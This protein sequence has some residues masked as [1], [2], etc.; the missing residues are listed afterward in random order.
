[1]H[2]H[3]VLVLRD[4]KRI[5]KRLKRKPGADVIGDLERI[6]RK[7]RASIR[8]R[9]KRKN[10]VPSFTYFDHL[11]ITSKKDEIIDAIKKNKVIVVS[12]ETGSGKT[13]QLPKF[14]LDA[15]RGIEGKIGCTQPRRIAATTVSRRIAE[16]MGQDIGQ[17]VGY[18]IRFQEKT[19]PDAYIKVMTDGILLAETQGDPWLNE[20]DTIIVD[21]AHERS[22][23]ID[24]VLGILQTLVEKRKNLKLIITSATI[25]TEKFSKAFGN[26]KVLEVSGRTYP[27]ETRYMNDTTDKDDDEEGNYVEMAIQ[28][29]ERIQAETP[30]GDI[31]V[32]MPTEHDIRE[33]CELIQG[34]KFKNTT[35][36]PLF[37]RL[38][39]S[40]Q[41]K[42]FSRPRGRKIIVATNIAETSITI[43][44]IKYVVDTGVARI[45]QYLPRSR[46]T[47]LP[48]VPVSRSSAD[49]RKGRCGRVEN[50][51]CIRLFSEEGYHQRPLFTQPEILRSNL[52]EV[53]LRM[54]ALKL[55]DITAFPFIDRPAGKSIKDGLDLLMELGAIERKKTRSIKKQRSRP[56]SP[57]YVLTKTGRIMAMLPIDPRLSRML[58]EGKNRGCLREMVILAGALS[59]QDPRERPLDK[60]AQA[61]QAHA[62]F[63]DP[64][65]DFITLLNI[66]DRFR[67]VYKAEKGMSRMRKF[68]RKNFLSFNR[69]REWGDI[70]IQIRAVLKE[71]GFYQAKVKNPGKPG[72]EKGPVE[73]KGGKE[74]FHPRYAA[75]HQSILSGF[76]SNIAEK[77][78]KHFFRAAKGREVMIFPGSGI[79]KDPGEWVVAAEMVETSRL[80]ARRVAA[81]NVSW[82]E[83]LGGDQ[84]KS[85]VSDPHWERNRGEVVAFEQVS[86]Y[87][88][89]I[90]KKRMVSYGRIN[91]DEASEIFIRGAL[92]EGD[93]R[94]PLSFMLHNR[95]LVDEVRDVENRIRRRDILIDDEDLV[96]FYKERLAGIFDIRTL[97]HMIRRKGSDRFLHMEKDK[98]YQ[99]RPD[100]EEIVLFPSTMDLGNRVF[101]CEYA[102]EPGTPEDGVTVSVPSDMAGSVDKKRLDWIVPGL[103]KE[104]LTAL[105]KGLPKPYRKKLVPVSGTVDLIASRMPVSSE[106]LLTSLSRFIHEQF[107]VDIPASVWDVDLVP[108]HLKMRISVTDKK[109]RVLRSGRDASILDRNNT[110]D[111]STRAFEDLKKEW[112]KKGI[113]DWDFGDLQEQVVCKGKGGEKWTVYPGLKTHGD[114]I[115]LTIFRDQRTSIDTHKKGV[116]ALISRKFTKEIKSLK[117]NLCFP[118][119][120]VIHPGYF[121]RAKSLE[122]QLFNHVLAELF[123]KNLR[124]RDTYLAGI[125]ALKKGSIHL[126]G[127]NR[128]KKI[129]VVLDAYHDLRSTIHTLETNF[130]ASAQTLAFFKS[131]REDLDQLVPKNF[132]EIYDKTRLC[133]LVRYI[134]AMVIRAERAGLDLARDRIKQDSI[135]PHIQNLDRLLAALSNKT[136]S[137]KRAAIENYFWMIQ[138]YKVS[139]FAQEIKTAVPVSGK[140]LDKKYSEIQRMI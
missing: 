71:H 129:M 131:L 105:V 102:F 35:V 1:M 17:A 11:P 113:V 13:T 95:K 120:V 75:I 2:V 16:E 62:V 57:A 124:T 99:Y 38:S 85:V 133:H 118:A 91:P 101:T 7:V 58:I 3:R 56:S 40:E 114:R 116:A 138:E 135:E 45:S 9:E 25:D 18:K 98:L 28:A 76:L 19:G 50:G 119:H 31:L 86:L 80:F 27:V 81:I 127:Q 128:L 115:D 32:F 103:F 104:K 137:E 15:G 140:R 134:K 33:T 44:G 66:W 106:N 4:L 47:S 36:L 74:Q 64:I 90:V 51:V 130:S 139:L 61:D 14:C 55:G 94:Q 22:L 89:V 42:V 23:N 92:V 122:N 77:K 63:K 24:F 88:L 72:K 53:I 5:R 126:K 29:I 87:G 107:N 59:L 117:R 96:R 21:E 136:S 100:H 79:F 49:Q 82:L 37:A 123:E 69:M 108:D 6:D 34:R 132:I 46:I 52:A 73:K 68:C 65:S 39:A 97:K 30:Y 112:E 70:Y 84:C 93:V 121:G 10:H 41:K 111:T 20:Y 67:A 48:V 109:G 8:T 54:I 78:E 110:A 12:G 83:P 125:D 43:P 26:A 60:Q